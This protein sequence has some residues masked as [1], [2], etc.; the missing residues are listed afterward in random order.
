MKKALLL[1]KE[2]TYLFFRIILFLAFTGHALVNLGLSSGIELHIK[3]IHE[4][5]F[6]DS[7]DPRTITKF[8]AVL[9][10][11]FAISIV[12]RPNKT[13]LIAGMIYLL[14]VGCAV[15]VLFFNKTDS[16]FGIAENM[17]R[18]PWIFYSLYLY[19]YLKQKVHKYHLLRIGISFAFLA[20]GTASLGIMGLSGG[21]V[22]LAAQIIPAEHVKDFVFYSGFFDT[23]IGLL[24]ITGL[25]SRLAAFIG[26]PWLI[27]I[28]ILSFMIG[29]PEGI[30]RSGFLFSLVYVALDRRC[31]EKNIL[32]FFKKSS[33]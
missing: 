12:I 30:F 22:E 17:R 33:V 26:I 24:L 8:L 2:N 27:F 14:L 1:L 9:D 19:Y 25:G 31:H 6:L 29:I 21:H 10:L 7:F 3:I 20:H 11:L 23:I 13:I 32:H 28:V 16:P 15:W 4:L 5:H 18:F